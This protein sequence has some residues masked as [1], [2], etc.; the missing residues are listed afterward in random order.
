M[1]FPCR[2]RGA[3]RA[4]C[5]SRPGRLREHVK[6]SLGI[7]SS[8]LHS[9]NSELEEKYQ[10]P[11]LPPGKSVLKNKGRDS[12]GNTRHYTLKRQLVT[13]LNPFFFSLIPYIP[14]I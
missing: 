13:S 11:P 5:T 1:T 10:I 8:T 4:L 3:G 7:M 12:G 6:A 2:G 14:H 9:L